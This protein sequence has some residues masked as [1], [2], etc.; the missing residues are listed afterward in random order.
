MLVGALAYSG[1][2]LDGVSR[3]Y[4]DT[5]WPSDVAAGAL[6]GTISGLVVTRHQHAHPDNRLDA[7]A[8][9]VLFAPAA[10]GR[11]AVGLAGTF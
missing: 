5:H 9:R 2:F 3:V 4:R 10:D 8:R 6:V 1:A 7:F 11:L